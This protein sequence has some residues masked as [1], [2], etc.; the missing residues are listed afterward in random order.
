MN[1][2]NFKMTQTI[3][4][5]KLTNTHFQFNSDVFLLNFYFD[6]HDFNILHGVVLI[7]V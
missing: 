6:L 4:T 5:Q 1:K 2:N 3:H 7:L